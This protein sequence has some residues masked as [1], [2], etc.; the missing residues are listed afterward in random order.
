MA[1][2]GEVLTD[3]QAFVNEFETTE[4]VEYGGPSSNT[5]LDAE[6]WAALRQAGEVGQITLTCLIADDQEN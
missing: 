5:I 4:P 3:E 1:Q 2:S 6:M